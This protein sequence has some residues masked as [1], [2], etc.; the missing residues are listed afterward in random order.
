MA[1][2][3]PTIKKTFPYKQKLITCLATTVSCECNLII[4]KL[5]EI[6]DKL[7][8][9][10][11]DSIEGHIENYQETGS[12]WYFKEVDKL[13]IHTVEYVTLHRTLMLKVKA[14][15]RHVFTLKQKNLF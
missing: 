4:D 2:Q 8:E 5:I 15:A 14:R 3:C 7:I 6:I 1:V 12:A 11:I 13:E 10:S 9:I